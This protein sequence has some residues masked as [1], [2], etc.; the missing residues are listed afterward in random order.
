[1]RATAVLG[2]HPHTH[3]A[4]SFEREQ[5]RACSLH[6]DGETSVR[7]RATFVPEQAKTAVISGHH[8]H[9]ERP[10]I[11]TKGKL[12]RC[13]NDFLSNGLRPTVSSN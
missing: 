8:G 7:E 13:V 12:T 4:A 5:G 6:P 10:P 1:M 3:W 2:T 11:W 9:R